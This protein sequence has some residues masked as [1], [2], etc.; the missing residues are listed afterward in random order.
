M[1]TSAANGTVAACLGDVRERMARACD[2]ARRDPAEVTLV[3]VTKTVDAERVREALDAGLARLGENRVQEAVAKMR[4]LS[5]RAPLWHLIG[6]LQKNKAR[7]AAEVFDRIESVDSIELARLLEEDAE[8]IGR[9]LH[10]FVQVNAFGEST[11][12]G[13]PLERLASLVAEIDA[14][15]NLTVT[16]LMAIPPPRTSSDASRRDF[17]ILRKAFDELRSHGPNIRHLSMGMSADFEEAIE[18]GSTEVRIGSAI[19]GRR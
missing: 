4:E 3:G 8:E 1:T 5:D 10:V 17:R 11:K 15:P 12:Q 2:R 19:F 7:L 6:H 13:V 14:L 9:Q 18:E 16:G